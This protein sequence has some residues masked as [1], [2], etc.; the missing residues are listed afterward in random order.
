MLSEHAVF[1]YG[2]DTVWNLFYPN[3]QSGDFT[4]SAT[5]TASTAPSAT[6]TNPTCLP[7]SDLLAFRAVF[8]IRNPMLMVPSM[9]RA[10]KATPLPYDIK[11]DP[12]LS[13]RYSRELFDWYQSQ[14]STTSSLSSASASLVIDADDIMKRPEVVEKMCRLVGLDA[15]ALQYSWG[16]EQ[17]AHPVKSRFK[18]TINSST[19]IVPGLD[20]GS[21]ELETERVKWIEELGDDEGTLLYDAVVKAMPDY[22]YLKSKC[23]TI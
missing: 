13:L 19:G 7:D 3:Q 4:V 20:S 17:E 15:D 16:T 23:L 14:A 12:C 11:F 6:R 22:Y 8:Q 18:S 21:M 5:K 10:A 9:V 2:P 1:L